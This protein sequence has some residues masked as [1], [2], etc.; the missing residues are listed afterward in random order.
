[1]FEF[2]LN[3]L[4]CTLLHILQVKQ[5]LDILIREISEGTVA[6]MA[7]QLLEGLQLDEEMDE[8][9]DDKT[10]EDI[11]VKTEKVEESVKM[12]EL[13]NGVRNV[14]EEI[15][16]EVESKKSKK[17]KKIDQEIAQLMTALDNIQLKDDVSSHL[18]QDMDFDALFKV[19][20]HY[21]Y[22]TGYFG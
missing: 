7:D 8:E 2:L 14:T 11:V 1:M 20:C 12:E 10:T 22:T 17:D 15:L 9:G 6:M 18:L 3:S 19:C 16:K 13:R 5:K 4:K 21:V